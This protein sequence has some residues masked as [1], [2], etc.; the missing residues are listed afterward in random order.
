MEKGI[1]E[2]IQGL[3]LNSPAGYYKDVERAVRDIKQYITEQKLNVILLLNTLPGCMEFLIIEDYQIDETRKL[4][5]NH[6]VTDWMTLLNHEKP[7]DEELKLTWKCVYDL[8]PDIGFELVEDVSISLSLQFQ[9]ISQNMDSILLQPAT[10]KGFWGQK[11]GDLTE[12]SIN[13]QLKLK[14][15][16]NL[17]KNLSEI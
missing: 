11:K 5:L 6:R 12:I 3:G 14:F 13:D 15:K 17:I 10:S 9:L 4:R 1:Y 8:N 2:I 7:V 16:Q